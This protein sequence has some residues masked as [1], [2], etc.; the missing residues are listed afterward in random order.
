MAKL[1]F[2]FCGFLIVE[3][4]FL[5]VGSMSLRDLVRRASYG[6][7]YIRLNAPEFPLNKDALLFYL[8]GIIYSSEIKQLFISLNYLSRSCIALFFSMWTNNVMLWKQNNSNF[9]VCSLIQNQTHLL[10]SQNLSFQIKIKVSLMLQ[11][12]PEK[13][14]LF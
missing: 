7:A 5:V 3:A 12:I 10:S 14:M 13:V 11:Q 4:T 6:F 8:T 2:S 9:H 1:S